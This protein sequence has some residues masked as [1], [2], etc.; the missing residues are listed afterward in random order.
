[1]ASTLFSSVGAARRHAARLLLPALAVWLIFGGGSATANGL[2]LEFHGG[3]SVNHEADF[4]APGTDLEISYDEGVALGVAVGYSFW[5]NW[6]AEG[7]FTIRRNDPDKAAG[8]VLTAGSPLYA[9]AIMA[10]VFYEFRGESN[11]VPYIGG[12]I[13]SATLDPDDTADDTSETVF[14]YQFGSGLGYELSESVTLTADYR[15]FATED[16]D[17]GQSGVT[18]ELEYSN[19]SVWLGLRYQF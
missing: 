3:L 6:R 10:N 15:Y 16:A 1:M 8:T 4:S 14:A 2:Y 9:S 18:A 13:G 11:W 5:L 17:F 19:S 12:G 7:E